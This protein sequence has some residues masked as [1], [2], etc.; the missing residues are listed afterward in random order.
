VTPLVEL[1][2]VR[3]AFP[4]PSGGQLEVLRHVN[5]TVLPG[6]VVAIMGRSGSGKSTLL[7]LLG[8][9]EKPTAGTYVLNGQETAHLTDAQAAALRGATIGFIFQQFHLMERRT[10]L[11]NVAEPLLYASGRAL[12]QRKTRAAELLALVGL[13]ERAHAMPSA[14]SGGEQ[15]RVA[16]AR[17]LVRQPR[18]VLAD[19][20]TGALDARTGEMVLDLLLGL[21]RSSGVTLLLVTHDQAIARR[22]DRVLMLVNGCLEETSA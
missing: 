2:E 21:V 12:T 1:R 19:E 15:Q 20:P 10:A 13:T 16:I 8:L 5:L 22:A 14:L 7:H 6:E 9:L 3:K 17:A 18:L 4:L 11:E